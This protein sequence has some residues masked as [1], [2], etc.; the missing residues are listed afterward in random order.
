MYDIVGIG[1][2]LVDELVLLPEYPELNTKIKILNTFKQ[3]GGPVPTSL[4]LLSNLGPYTAFYGK[5]GNDSNSILQELQK[6]LWV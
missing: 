4:R 5:I 6:Y 1:S 3:V 2:I